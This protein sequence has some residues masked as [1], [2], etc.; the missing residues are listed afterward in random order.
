M[1]S[2]SP[3][4]HLRAFHGARPISHRPTSV[5]IT[6]GVLRRSRCRVAVTDAR[7]NCILRNDSHSSFT[8]RFLCPIE[9][10]RRC[11]RDYRLERMRGSAR[12]AG[13]WNVSLINR[14]DQEITRRC[15]PR[16]LGARADLYLPR[17]F[18]FPPSGY[19]TNVTLIRAIDGFQGK[20]EMRDERK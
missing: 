3:P 4:S 14:H 15:M 11:A 18:H 13:S 19:F 5:P 20:R 8:R 12:F 2:H 6:G 1:Y 9:S 17:D 10:S 16:A 7:I